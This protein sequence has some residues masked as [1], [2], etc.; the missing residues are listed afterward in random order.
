[1]TYVSYTQEN[2][3]ENA[4]IILKSYNEVIKLTDIEISLLYYL[5]AAKLCISVCNSAY[6]K[7]INPS[8]KYALISE[9]NAWKMLRYLV[10]I[11]PEYV[12]NS[13]R[14]ILNK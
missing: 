12:E 6:S 4:S 7:K 5:M 1:M 11:S 10:K 9:K 2:P 3:L 13:F 8:N 14:K